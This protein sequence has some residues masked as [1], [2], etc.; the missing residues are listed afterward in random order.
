[1]MLTATSNISWWVPACSRLCVSLAPTAHNGILL[2]FQMKTIR[3][4]TVGRGVVD[5]IKF[6]YAKATLNANTEK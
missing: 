4:F 6:E 2:L 3:R 5:D 1:M